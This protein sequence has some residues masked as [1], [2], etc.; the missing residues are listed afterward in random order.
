MSIPQIPIAKINVSA[1][2]VGA[3]RVDL[4]I[5]D[6][7][8]VVDEQAKLGGTNS[9][10]SPTDC[11]LAALASCVSISTRVLSKKMGLKVASVDVDIDADF[12]LR[13]VLL[14]EEIDVPFKKINLQLKLIADIESSDML[15]LKQAVH[16]F[17]P[18]HKLFSTAGT[19]IIEDWQLIQS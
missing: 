18:L 6:L 4:N 14:R 7:E 19:E 17:C 5:R 8:F 12:D 15:K 16:S 9:G 10:P 13:G 3:M 2:S 11:A 1:R